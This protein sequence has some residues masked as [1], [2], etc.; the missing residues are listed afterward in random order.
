[1][2][3][4]VSAARRIE[5]E[6]EREKEA[7]RLR[8]LAELERQKRAAEDRCVVSVSCPPCGSCARL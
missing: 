3:K 7:A 8:M 4:A 5:V 6:L 2:S 1:M